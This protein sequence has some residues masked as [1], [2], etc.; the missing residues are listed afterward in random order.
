MQFQ[1][2]TNK[3]EKGL[4]KNIKVWTKQHKDILNDLDSNDRYIV[5]RE[6]I[7]NKMEDHAGIY[8][9]T[10]AWLYQS[11]SKRMEI[12][13]DASYPIWLSVTEES[14]IGNS[15]G[16]VSLELLV[17][18]EKVLIMDLEKWGYIVNYMYIPKDKEDACKHEELLVN[19]GID[20][21]T[22]YMS[23]FYPNIKSKII[24]SWD[25]LFDDSI[26]LSPAL[27]GIMWELKKEWITNIER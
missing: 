4:K 23:P 3:Q 11:V 9:D 2:L 18:E 10:Y 22:A 26:S 12:P 27:V 8:F 25:R 6:Y 17:E 13:A 24:K 5:K 19:Y 14:K 7:L 20:D 21:S 15:E 16:N 1:T